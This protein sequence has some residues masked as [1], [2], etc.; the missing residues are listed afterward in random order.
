LN[1][2][3]RYSEKIISDFNKKIEKLNY[4]ISPETKKLKSHLR[5]CYFI[6]IYFLIGFAMLY[7]FSLLGPNNPEFNNFIPIGEKVIILIATISILTFTYA[8]TLEYPK[9]EVVANSGKYFF[10]SV[11]YFIIGMILLIGLR[12]NLDNP[13]NNFGLPEFVFNISTVF[14][15]ILF[16]SGFVLLL[17]SAYSFA[18]G[19]TDLLKSL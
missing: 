9:K 2:K 7:F 10:K 12:N 1:N 5:K 6:I 16:L 17:I 3:T 11:L 13:T 14:T 8:L 15:L 19:I 18:K 4:S